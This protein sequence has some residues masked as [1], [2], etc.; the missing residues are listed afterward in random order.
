VNKKYIIMTPSYNANSGGVVVLHKLCDQ[1][2]R[3]GYTA[4]VMP[5]RYSYYFSRYNIL[6][7][8]FKILK[9]S[10]WNWF[11][12]YKTNK[13]FLTPIFPRL[14]PVTDD[15]I[16]VYPEVVF[17]NPLRAKHVVRWLLHQPG[18]HE[19]VFFYSVGE[20]IYR[21]NSAVFDFTYPG[22]F[23]SDSYLKVIHYPTEL[24][25]PPT[26]DEDR[27]GVA[28][29]IRK[30]KG[31]PFVRD[32][33]RDIL[34][35][36][37]DHEQVANAFRKSE[38][39]ICYDEHT[40]YSIFATLCGCVSVVI[41]SQGVGIDK[42]YPDEA[43]RYGIAYGFEDIDRAKATAGLVRERILNEEK[44]CSSRVASFASE[45]QAFFA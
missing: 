32:H 7:E 44:E 31:K 25:Y 12:P 5:Y 14:K 29:C 19:G 26:G 10:V 35:D 15:Y 45:S 40:A 11:R 33:S 36:H 37:L 42:W 24:Y 16:V 39:F 9:W 21:F 3:L 18:Y 23:T 2:N 43:D 38:Y 30:G 8:C 22:S 17:G 13:A 34:I 6:S 27:S 20:L 28:Y 4:F 41:P 1:L